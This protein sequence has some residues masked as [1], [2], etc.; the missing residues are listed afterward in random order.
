ME[1]EI[2]T[3]LWIE[4]SAVRVTADY[5]DFDGSLEKWKDAFY[6]IWRYQLTWD[7]AHNINL[8]E[9]RKTGVYICLII[10]KAYQKQVKEMLESLGYRNIHERKETIGLVPLYT[11]DDPAADNVFEVFAD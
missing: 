5:E 8:Y 10:K 1:K 2:K 11:I 6:Q 3:R 7:F 4:D 9:R